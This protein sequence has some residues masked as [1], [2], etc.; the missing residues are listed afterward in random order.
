MMSD[1]L[2]NLPDKAKWQNPLSP[3]F[4]K[5]MTRNGIVLENDAYLVSEHKLDGF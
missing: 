1:I 5:P 4:Y 2:M 3:L